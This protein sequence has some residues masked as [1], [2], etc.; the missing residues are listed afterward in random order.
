[1]YR[2][3]FSAQFL[4]RDVWHDERLAF[5]S[6]ETGG[7]WPPDYW[8]GFDAIAAAQLWAPDTQ[9]E[10]A[11]DAQ[12][13]SHAV[14]I[15]ADGRVW[16]IRRVQARALCPMDFT[17]LP[18][19]VQVCK[20]IVGTLRDSAQEVTFRPLRGVY[21]NRNSADAS[22]SEWRLERHHGQPAAPQ[23]YGSTDTESLVIFK[24]H[25]ARVSDF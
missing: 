15:R 21:I 23:E 22:V 4:V 1:M 12:V 2:Q 5:N 3:T 20:L 13:H 14:W 8:V 24:F 25:L 17:D 19:D 7:C 11:L 16:R 10:N 18:F 6:T 9:I